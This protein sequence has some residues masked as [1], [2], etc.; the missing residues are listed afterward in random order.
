MDFEFVLSRLL[1]GFDRLKIRY[2][3]MGGFAL[4]ALGAPRTTGDLDFLVHRD[5]MRRVHDLLTGLGYRR[6]HH[7]ENLSQYLGE[8]IVWGHLDFLH[9]FRELA[10]EMLGRAREKPIFSGSR[11]IRVLTPEDIIGLKVQCIANAP[12]RREKELADIKALALANPKM[13]WKRVQQFYRLF[14]MDADYRALR[15]ELEA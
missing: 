14:D 7:S 9:A 2:G 3:L 1:D 5:D 15:R 4:G 8:S 13:E 12:K 6:I 11:G 10:V